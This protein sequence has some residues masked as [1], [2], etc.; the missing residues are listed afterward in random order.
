MPRR[1]VLLLALVV[2]AAA[3][4]GGGASTCDSSKDC[5]AY[6]LTLQLDWYPN[7]DHVGLYTTIDHGFFKRIG[8]I[9]VPRQ[10][11][12]VSDPIK[13]VAT[14]RADLGI[15]YEPELFFAQQRQAPVVA[16]SAII[17]TA[18]NSVIVPGD[19]GVRTPADL[20][21]K[22]I[23]VDGSD[24]TSAYLDTMLRSVGL[25]PQHDV[26]TVNV[27][28]NLLPALLGGKVDAI[29]GGFQNIE[30]AQLEVRGLHPVVFPVDEYGVPTYD[31]L[32]VV[33][34]SDRLRKDAQYRGMVRRFVHAL[35][36]GTAYAKAH[37]G[38]AL[39]A[40]RAHASSDYKSVLETSV[41]ETLRLLD[42]TSLD[43]KAWD[44]FGR[45]MEAQGLL[46]TPPDG[47]ALVARP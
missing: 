2:L 18:L 17:P 16:V 20:R 46:D 5:G 39:E 22:T 24:S 27:G 34:N 28:F 15:S 25:D 45:W 11:S 31:E 32:V 40:M 47:A 43:P 3:C 19:S 9:V 44:A 13:L 30:G 12:D 33:A 6:R 35:G 36:A 26:H 10:P 37:P 21:G 8:L 23:G 38:A 14:G 1:L 29:A 7:P 41:P 4:G 42:T